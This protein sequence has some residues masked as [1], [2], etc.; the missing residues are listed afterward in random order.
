[1]ATLNLI[2][3]GVP[4]ILHDRLGPSGPVR[5]LLITKKIKGKVYEGKISTFDDTDAREVIVKLSS[6]LEDIRELEHEHEIYSMDLLQLQGKAIP[7]CLGL[8]KGCT[9]PSTVELMACLILEKCIPAPENTISRHDTEFYRQFML[10]LC[11]IHA[12]GVLHNGLE[13]SKHIVMQSFSPRIIDFSKA[14]RHECPGSFP[15]DIYGSV[16]RTGTTCPELVAL[17]VLYG[18]RSC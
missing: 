16:Q 10:N 17:E 5:T 15:A 4:Y 3:K 7:R 8:F 13:K 1:M 9:V 6:K 18:M 11:Q 2:L 14:S 12:A